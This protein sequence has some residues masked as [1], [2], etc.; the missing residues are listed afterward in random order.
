M[1]FFA[2]YNIPSPTNVIPPDTWEKLLLLHF[3]SPELQL[4]FLHLSSSEPE[5]DEARRQL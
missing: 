2:S 4:Q 3:L 5:Q 1:T